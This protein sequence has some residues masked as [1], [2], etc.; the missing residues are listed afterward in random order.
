M[1]SF[2]GKRDLHCIRRSDQ[3]NQ[4]EF[5]MSATQQETNLNRPPKKSTFTMRSPTRVE[6]QPVRTDR[7]LRHRGGAVVSEESGK[8][9]FLPL[10][11][12]PK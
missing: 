10:H 5:A 1:S 9:K 2:F 3:T 4:T 6:T 11:N 8:I 12:N 7:L